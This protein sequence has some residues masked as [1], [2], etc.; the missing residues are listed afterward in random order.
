[1]SQPA[2]WRARFPSRAKVAL[3]V[4]ALVAVLLL[5]LFVGRGDEQ[6]G[7]SSLDLVLEELE[8]RVRAEPQ[9]L[10]ARL[11]VAVAYLERG[12]VDNAISQFEQALTLEP[13]NQTALIGLGQAHLAVGDLEAAEA[14]LRR[15][16]ELNAD[17]EF[18]YTLEQLEGVHYDLAS[19]EL[20]RGRF[21]EAR[22]QLLE[23]LKINGTDADAWRMLGSAEEQSGELGAAVSAYRRAVR[24]VPDYID[25][26]RDLER[27]YESMGLEG[28]RLY[29]EGMVWLVEGAVAEAIDPL[30]RAVAAAPEHAEAHEGLGIAYEM[31]GRPQD[32]LASYRTALQ[33]DPEMFL[34]G[35]AVQRLEAG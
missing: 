27:V 25:V 21:A 11:A 33:L 35:L 30:E 14:P 10:D 23:A 22:E 24:L 5:V 31:A 32:A 34:S 19:I 17:N 8:E 28:H 13:E 2:A 7:R 3:A 6:S 18:R 4:L 9:D 1:M 29:A 16:I 12:L 20:E 26:Y 15:V